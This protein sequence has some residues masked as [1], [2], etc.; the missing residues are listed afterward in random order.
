MGFTTS[1]AREPILAAFVLWD[2]NY[3]K[4]NKSVFLACGWL[5]RAQRA[6]LYQAKR[7]PGSQIDLLTCKFLVSKL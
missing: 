2:S 3:V 4:L 5:R 1:P 6:D 7:T